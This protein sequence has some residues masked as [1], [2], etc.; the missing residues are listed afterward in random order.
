MDKINE[1]TLDEFLITLLTFEKLDNIFKKRLPKDLVKY[2]YEYMEPY[3]NDCKN[4]C[5][6]C[7]YYC[8][9]DCL[10]FENRD[11]CCKGELQTV[12]N[13]YKINQEIKRINVVGLIDNV[14][15][16]LDHNRENEDIISDSDEYLD[17]D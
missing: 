1:E 8:S 14:I 13:R 4:C 10:R 9:I 5:K 7:L 2:I 3:C 16:V 12:I 15:N 17:I 11:I 6:L